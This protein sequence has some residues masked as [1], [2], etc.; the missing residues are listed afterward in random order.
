[1]TAESTPRAGARRRAAIATAAK[2]GL[3]CSSALFALGFAELAVRVVLPQQLISI[4][5]DI[6]QPHDGLGWVVRP[7]IDTTINTGERTVRVRTDAR[8]FRVGDAGRREGDREIL[9]LGDS[10]MQALQVEHEQSLPGLIEARLGESLASDAAA[11]VAV[12]VRNGGVDGWDPAQYLLRARSELARRHYDALVVAVYLG[13]DVIARARDHFPPRQAVEVHPL[14]WP[15]SL[16][17]ED[18]VDSVF[19]P[20][21]D[22]LEVRSHLFVLA[23]SSL[24]GL[25]IR[26]G[27]SA[28]YLPLGVRLDEA[29][30]P[31]WDV[32]LEV[33]RQIEASA[34]ERGT[35]ALFV[36]IPAPFA[37]DPQVFEQIRSGFEIDESELDASQ[38][39]R[40]VA[41]R[42]AAAGIPHVSLVE[43]FLAEHRSGTPLYGRVDRHLSPEGHEVAY[44]VIEPRLLEMLEADAP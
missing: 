34:R 9:V 7:E 13:N 39:G 17:W 37:I 28:D 20:V 12:A 41:G 40:I 27:L 6:W 14:R 22:W 1:M 38:P 19:Y 5:P 18:W 26:L 31:R 44:D 30:D 35:P 24:R 23:R 11:P 8:G 42:L 10:F 2:L 4:R 3:L 15:G 25:L 29:D 16:A 33:L 21:N 43:R 36:L 32:T